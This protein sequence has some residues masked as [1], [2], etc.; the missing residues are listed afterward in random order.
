MNSLA[1]ILACSLLPMLSIAQTP[2]HRPRIVVGI[3]VD[4]MRW[5]YLYR[6]YDRYTEGGFKRLMRDGFRCEQTF[7]N[8]LPSYT[9]PGHTTIYTGTTPAFHGIVG[10]DWLEEKGFTSVYCCADTQVQS[11][12]GAVAAG[13][14]SPR[15]MKSNTI[16]DELRLATNFRSRVFGVSLKDRG[17]ILPAGHSAN[18]AF[19]FDDSTGNFISSS[20]YYS[21]LPDWVRRFNAT[22]YADSLLSVPWKLMRPADSYRQS[23]ADNNAYEYSMKGESAPVFPHYFKMGDYK[24]IRRSPAGN[25]LSFLFAKQLI[26]AEKIGSDECDFLALSLSATDYVGHAYA[27]NAMEVEDMYLRLD[28]Q[29]ASFLRFLDR[30][31]GAG[32]YLI[33]LTADHGAAHNSEWLHSQKIPAGSLPE[34]NLFRGLNAVL[35]SRFRQ[36]SL[37]RG[38]MNYQVFFDEGRIKRSGIGREIIKAEVVRWCREQTGVHV[39][40]D[41]E[42]GSTTLIPL[43]L[44]SL[45]EEGYY[46]PRSGSVSVIYEPAW[47]ADGKKGTTHG[48]WNPYDRHIPLL[49]YGKGVPQGSS[50]QQVDMSDI[51]VTLAAM[52]QIQMPNAA[53]GRVITDLLN[54]K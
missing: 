21:Q 40:A 7:V 51:A 38:V 5:D 10:N 45:L 16:G 49:W 28:R 15:N 42:R 30:R 12:G 35:K 46:A 36:D 53:T 3:V 4:Q 2:N 32:E 33:F 52:L 6:F 29:L 44:R 27:P 41:L 31:F 11:L 25:Q 9:A 23:I 18:G 13:Q 26:D 48:T 8:Y 34:S 37:V 22:R 17:A 14:M 54:K 1:K 47:Y 20:Y 43:P 39:V 50:Y 19:W 24:A